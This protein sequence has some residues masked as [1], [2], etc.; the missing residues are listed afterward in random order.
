MK[1]TTGHSLKLKIHGKGQGFE[2]LASSQN[3]KTKDIWYILPTNLEL[4]KTRQLHY[5]SI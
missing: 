3:E 2:D 5:F 4:E 1:L